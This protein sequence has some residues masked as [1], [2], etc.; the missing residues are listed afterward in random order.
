VVG[1]LASHLCWSGFRYS[2]QSFF[3]HGSSWP[4]LPGIGVQSTIRAK[5]GESINHLPNSEST[6]FLLLVSFGRCKFKLSEYSVGLI[7]QATIGGAAVDF[8]PQQISDRVFSFVVASQNV[9]FHVYNL[10]SYNCD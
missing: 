5:F 4:E 1:S 10:K 7:L 2:L 8:R 9:G 3:F 6:G